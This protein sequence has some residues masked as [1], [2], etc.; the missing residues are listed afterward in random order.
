MS[1]TKWGILATGEIAAAFT[2]E[3]RLLPDAE[4]VAVGSRAPETAAAFA[5]RHGVPRAYGSWAELAADDEVDIV[6]VANTHNAHREAVLT[7]LKAG[8]AVLCEK[9][10]TLNAAEAAELVEFAREA[11]LFLMEAMWMRC[12]PAIR[13]IA[14]LVEAGAIGSVVAVHADFGISVPPDPG[15]RL[16]DPA[17]GGGALLDLGVYPISFAHLVLGPP[18]RI[19]AWARLTPEGVDE[20]TGVLLGHAGGAVALLSCGIAAESPGT[21]SITGTLGRIDLPALFFQPDT[22]TL[23]RAGAGPRTFH[24]PYEG[25]GLAHE[26]VEA[27]RCLREGLVESPL[28]PWRATLEVMGVMDAV[29]ERIGVRFPGE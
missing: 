9:A 1:V 26:A 22:F 7:C 29:R 21:A 17:Q 24:V 15:H 28:V 13:R 27:M 23:H 2:E 14:E 12:N 6:Y 8:R 19:E 11:G 16:R 25:T 18:E 10:F 3:L 5:E 4:V 20:N